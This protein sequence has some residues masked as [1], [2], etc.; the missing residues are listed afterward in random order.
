MVDPITSARIWHRTIF[1]GIAALV[2][3]LRLLPLSPGTSGYIGPDITLAL[4]LAWVLRR[5]DYVPA[6]LILLVL[7]AEDLMFQRAPGLWP[8]IV[9]MATQMLRKREE[10]FR[11][12]PFIFEFGLVALILLAM[13][14]AQRTVLF[15][16]VVPQPGLGAQLLHML[17]TLVVYPVVV[18]ISAFMLGIKRPAPGEVDALGHPL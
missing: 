14:A 1:I 13:M 8:L 10:G 5:P 15:L 17:Q 7:V 3:F 6:F 11:E 18:A 12:L 2:L 9:L 16:T 4:I